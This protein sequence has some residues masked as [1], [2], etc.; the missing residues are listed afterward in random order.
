MTLIE[1]GSMAGATVA[2]ITLISKLVALITAIQNLICR[3]DKMAIE[4]EEGNKERVILAQSISRQDIKIHEI[5]LLFNN[6]KYELSELK[7]TVKEWL[8]RVN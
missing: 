1:I 4:I 7:A 5:E 3:L 2:I 6:I 8:Q